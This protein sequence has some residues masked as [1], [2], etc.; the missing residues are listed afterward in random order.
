VIAGNYLKA[1]KPCRYGMAFLRLR[2]K[3]RHS[4][5]YVCILDVQS[6]FRLQIHIRLVNS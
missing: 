1:K 2:G 5:I 3:N 4:V 6:W